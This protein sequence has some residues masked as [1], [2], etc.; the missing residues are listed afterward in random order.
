MANVSL[1]ALLNLRARGETGYRAVSSPN[2]SF[3]FVIVARRDIGS[4]ATLR[5]KVFGVGK[6]GSLDYSLSS[7]VLKREHFD[8]NDMHI[9][10]IG[11]PRTRLQAL[12]NGK[13]DATTV[14]YGTWTP[15][16]DKACTD[17]CFS[18]SDLESSAQFWHLGRPNTPIPALATWTDFSV[19]ADALRQ[20]DGTTRGASR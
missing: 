2:K 12:V 6:V 9:V 13:I 4:V 19:L 1:D 10:S 16:Q 14:L 11:S 7:A 20:L 17:G 8:P 15:L 18:R 5:G 3:S